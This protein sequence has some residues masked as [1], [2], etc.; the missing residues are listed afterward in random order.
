[1]S[2]VIGGL[3]SVN[4]GDFIVSLALILLASRK[5]EFGK[6]HLSQVIVLHAILAYFP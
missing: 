6:K 2:I 4:A 3:V 5:S 1:M